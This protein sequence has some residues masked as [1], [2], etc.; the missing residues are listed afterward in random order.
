[1]LTVPI[2]IISVAGPM[3][4]VTGKMTCLAAD[5]AIRTRLMS[6]FITLMFLGGGLG[7]WVG[8][9]AFDLGGWSLNARLAVALSLLT[10][11]LSCLAFRLAPAADQGLG[12]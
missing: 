11:L 10:V 1:M 4:D 3:I 8:T 12:S 7:S 5:P 6:L 2:M 9:I